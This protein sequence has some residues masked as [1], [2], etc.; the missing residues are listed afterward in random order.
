MG[1][2]KM[3]VG[4]IVSLAGASSCIAGVFLLFHGP[5]AHIQ[6]SDRHTAVVRYQ[7]SSVCGLSAV[8]NISGM[9]GTP[10]EI[11]EVYGRVGAP[12]DHKRGISLLSCKR[13]LEASGIGCTSLQFE[14]TADLPEATPM[15]L[16]ILH[17]KNDQGENR[18]HALAAIRHD[19]RVLLIDGQN[20]STATVDELDERVGNVAIVTSTLRNPH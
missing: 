10:L 4:T 19:T 15:I 2:A 7:G 13:A 1:R 16:T 17:G 20:V 9:Y 5:D 3:I 12:I 11:S 8:A 14:S 18:L 6:E